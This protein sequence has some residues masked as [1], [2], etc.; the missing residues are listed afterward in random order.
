MI[1][2][3]FR[4]GILFTCLIACCFLTAQSQKR[5]EE[6]YTIALPEQKVPDSRYN[7]LLFI[8]G[9]ADTSQMGIVQLGAFNKKAFVVPETPLDQQL[10]AVFNQLIDS[11]AKQGECVFL[12]R[13][14]SFAEITK[15][16]SERG[17]CYLRAAL[18]A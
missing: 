15:A 12:L 7:S 5:R 3:Y 2:M 13:Q 6:K 14:F 16:M 4:S 9:R 10:Q 11:S 8:D 18:F 1:V 17:Y